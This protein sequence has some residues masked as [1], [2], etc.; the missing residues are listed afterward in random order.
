[1]AKMTKDKMVE[2]A[3]RQSAKITKCLGYCK[4]HHCHLTLKNINNMN[5]IKK[6]CR[7]F[8]KIE[9]HPYWLELIRK[10]EEKNKRKENRRNILN[11]TNE[12]I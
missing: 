4:L 10:E 12:H 5:C 3:F 1:M 8:T 2:V 11:G 7:H 6:N 9:K